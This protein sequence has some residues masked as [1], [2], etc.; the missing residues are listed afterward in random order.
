MVDFEV[1]YLSQLYHMLTIWANISHFMI[2]YYMANISHFMIC[3][4]Y[5]L[6]LSLYDMLTTYLLTCI[7]EVA[8]KQLRLLHSQAGDSTTVVNSLSP[9]MSELVE[10]AIAS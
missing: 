5:I 6:Y 7:L 2:S 4:L 3:L 9:Q 8:S 10:D 1:F